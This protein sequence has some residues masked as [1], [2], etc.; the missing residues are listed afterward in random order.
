MT[1][2]LRERFWSFLALFGSF[3]TLVCCVLPALL[4]SLGLGATLVGLLNEFPFLIQLSES[5]AT[6]FGIS[7]LVLAVGAFVHW[8]NRNAPCPLDPKLREAC[9]SGRKWSFRFLV[10]SICI[11]LLGFSFAFVLPLVS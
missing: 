5:K 2:S 8:K 9:L 7:G 4:V 10:A 1:I 11:Y 6:V 3:G